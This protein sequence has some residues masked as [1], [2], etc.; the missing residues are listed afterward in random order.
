MSRKLILRSVSLSRVDSSFG[1]SLL[2][3]SRLSFI[4][5]VFVVSDKNIVDI[6]K[7]A[8]DIMV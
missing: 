5:V 7:V 2:N 3:Q 8:F 4:L 6:T 1:I